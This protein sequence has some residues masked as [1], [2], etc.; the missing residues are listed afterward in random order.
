MGIGHLGIGQCLIMFVRDRYY[1]N[2]NSK[3]RPPRWPILKWYYGCVG[4]CISGVE[5]KLQV[6]S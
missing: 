2:D 6:N 1:F 4:A 5:L 3:P